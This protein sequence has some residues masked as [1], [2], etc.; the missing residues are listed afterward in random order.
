MMKKRFSVIFISLILT[1]VML[2]LTGC[3]MTYRKNLIK[4]PQNVFE[5][6]RNM[7][8][9]EEHGKKTPLSLST[10]SAYNDYDLGEFVA[11]HIPDCNMYI[12][13]NR[14]ANAD[15]ELTIRFFNDDATF[16]Y[17]HDT[18]TL[19][20]E[21]ELSYMEEKFLNKYFEWT[22]ADSGY[23]VSE[24]SEDALG[25]F[26]FQYEETVHYIDHSPDQ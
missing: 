15:P 2:S 12:S 3:G 20:G 9:N 7:F 21:K 26:T 14:I 10:E 6:I 24:F 23:F 18:K 1:L 8:V 22:S 13:W 19:Y 11:L 16:I 25:D 5:E 4:E 17:D